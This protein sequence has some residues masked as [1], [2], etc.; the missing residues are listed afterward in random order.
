MVAATEVRR[1]GSPDMASERR[2]LACRVVALSSAKSL[3][4]ASQRSHAPLWAAPA[5]V[6]NANADDSP[7]LAGPCT[8]T[9]VRVLR[10]RPS[11]ASAVSASHGLRL[12]LL[13]LPHRPSPPMQPCQATRQLAGRSALAQRLLAGTFRSSPAK[14]SRRLRRQPSPHRKHVRLLR[15]QRFRVRRGM[16]CSNRAR[17]IGGCSRPAD[18]EGTR[19]RTN[20]GNRPVAVGPT[21]HCAAPAGAC[22]LRAQGR[23]VI[24]LP[25]APGQSGQSRA[26]RS[27]LCGPGGA[28]AV[29][30]GGQLPLSTSNSAL[31]ANSLDAATLPQ[32][33]QLLATSGPPGS[34]SRLH[35]TSLQPG[36]EGALVRPCWGHV[37]VKRAGPRQAGPP[38]EAAH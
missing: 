4:L 22:A 38:A 16:R 29:A 20:G 9:G 26:A 12:V 33:V 10:L 21:V 11:R 36:G 23:P 30:Q 37:V 31:A 2:R 13:L 7:R 17:V 3:P 25:R 24:L 14:A 27:W 34:R 19:R 5:P 15:K 35:R 8:R 28:D 18:R 6:R 32:L 1:T